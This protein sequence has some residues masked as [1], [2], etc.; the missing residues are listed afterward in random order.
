M[1]RIVGGS[2]A[3]AT[4]GVEESEQVNGAWRVS[5][6]LISPDKETILYEA[7]ANDNLLKRGIP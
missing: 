2:I 3:S 4:V 1:E 7:H 6:F 5:S